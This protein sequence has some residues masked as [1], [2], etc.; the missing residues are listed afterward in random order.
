M[1]GSIENILTQ[2]VLI[3]AIPTRVRNGVY[4]LFPTLMLIFAMPQIVLY[5]WIIQ[6]FGVPYSL[7]ICS[8]IALIGVFLV[9]KGFSYPIPKEESVESQVL[10]NVT[11]SDIDL[12]DES[13]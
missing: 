10:E 1:F 8:F 5:G 2:R 7:L 6:K 9:R 13:T 4:S 3:D 12:E 11:N